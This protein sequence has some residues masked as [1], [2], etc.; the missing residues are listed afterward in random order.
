MGTKYLEAQLKLTGFCFQL[1]LVKKSSLSTQG[2][3][4]SPNLL[5]TAP[6]PRKCI[7][8]TL[9]VID[10][11][12]YGLHTLMKY[13]CLVFNLPF[14]LEDKQLRMALRGAQHI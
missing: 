3:Q 1:S 12:C 8:S 4:L 7:L 14:I 5:E 9:I 6:H 2:S 11:T 13:F 10:F